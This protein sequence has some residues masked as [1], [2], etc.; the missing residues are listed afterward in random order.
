MTGDAEPRPGISTFQ[1]MFFVSLH[2]SGGVAVVDTPV[3]CG[4]RH[5]GQNRSAACCAVRTGCGT[6]SK[7]VSDAT[8]PTM[9][10][11]PR[12]EHDGL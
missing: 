4:P 1:R 5:C 3:A 8:A 12:K 7:R 9:D 2:S 11:E 6:G 10:V